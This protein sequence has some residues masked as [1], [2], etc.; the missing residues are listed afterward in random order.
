MQY[1]VA[2]IARKLHFHS[3]ALEAALLFWHEINLIMYFP[4]VLPHL[5][6]L[7]HDAVIAIISQLYEHHIG[8]CDIPE[9]DV[10]AQDE[11]HFRDQAVF[12]ADRVASLKNDTILL[13]D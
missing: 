9:A 6:V 12:D 7:Q 3:Y 4:A 11:M 1:R 13:T 10:T 5:V 8:I 2:E